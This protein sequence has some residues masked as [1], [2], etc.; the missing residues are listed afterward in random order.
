M[1]QSAKDNNPLLATLYLKRKEDLPLSIN[2]YASDDPRSLAEVFI[3]EN[4]LS[5]PLLSRL[6][7][8]ISVC[9]TNALLAN[10]DEVVESLPTVSNQQDS[11][12]EAYNSIKGNWASMP[13]INC[14]N[15]VATQLG[16]TQYGSPRPRS[17]SVPC[18][19]SKSSQ[20]KNLMF[21]RH[22]ESNLSTIRF[23]KLQAR[24]EFERQNNIRQ[25]SFR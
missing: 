20:N 9:K 19:V 4:N 17:S 22:N 2:I 16:P 6:E 15:T 23:A 1:M 7:T 10:I 5:Q 25:S 24:I 13:L 8:E 3:K 14:V 12:E 11:D 18:R 21:D